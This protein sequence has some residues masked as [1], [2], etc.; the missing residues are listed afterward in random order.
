MVLSSVRLFIGDVRSSLLSL[1]LGEDGSVVATLAQGNEQ[2]AR[3]YIVN[4]CV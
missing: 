3:G 4:A 1:L 2:T